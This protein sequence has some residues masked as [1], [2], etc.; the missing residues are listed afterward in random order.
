MVG[1]VDN[2]LNMSARS[3]I[4]GTS[5]HKTFEIKVD[6]EIKAKGFLYKMLTNAMNAY[7]QTAL[8]DKAI[9]SVVISKNK[10]SFY[11]DVHEDY[12]PYYLPLFD[13][14]GKFKFG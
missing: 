12:L 8:D 10:N 13:E 4:S 14:E 5:H 7:N 11:F 3:M 6:E 2:S 9:N 1:G